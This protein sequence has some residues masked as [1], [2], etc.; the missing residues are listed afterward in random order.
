MSLL[1]W[2]CNS[3]LTHPLPSL[4]P[5]PIHSPRATAGLFLKSNVQHFLQKQK[6]YPKIHMESQGTLNNQNN[7][8]KEQTR[9]HN[10]WFQSLLRSCVVLYLDTQSCPTLA[11]RWTAACQAPLS[12]GILQARILEWV[13]MASSR[14]SSQP[15]DRT[16]ASCIAGRFFTVWAI[17]E[18][19]EYWNG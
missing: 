7:L 9:R 15:R 14:G 17:R 13:A 12:M 5:F 4:W 3:I 11:T 1:T 6:T 16:Q 10:F 19:Q 18:A 8:E 2:L